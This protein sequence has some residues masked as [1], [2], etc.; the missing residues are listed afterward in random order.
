M[1]RIIRSRFV[2]GRGQD[3]LSDEPLARYGAFMTNI[4]NLADRRHVLTDGEFQSIAWIN[5]IDP[6]IRAKARASLRS[7][8]V[9]KGETICGIG[10]PV[11]YWI[12]VVDGLLKI[13]NT[14]ANGATLTFSG[15]PSGAWFSEGTVL[16]RESYRYSVQALRSSVIAGIS[17][18]AFFELLDESISFNRFIMLQLNERLSQF[19]GALESDR[20]D[21]PDAKVAHFLAQLFSPVLYPGVGDMLKISQVELAYLVGLSRQRVNRAL[22]TLEREGLLTLEF[23]GL[24]VVD[25]SELDKFSRPD[26]GSRA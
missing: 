13:G 1:A 10:D 18:D 22:R 21:T 9:E 25:R 20:F 4:F 14:A 12:G 7:A 6:G 5:A 23:G 16:K 11:R 26:S 17:V 24:R 19:M 2:A 3:D 8:V 15:L